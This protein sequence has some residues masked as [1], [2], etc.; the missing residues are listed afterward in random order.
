M[1]IKRDVSLHPITTQHVGASSQRQYNADTKQNISVYF[2]YSN[3]CDRLAYASS[4]DPDQTTPISSLIRFYTVCRSTCIL[5]AHNYL[6]KPKYSTFKI[7]TLI[8]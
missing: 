1:F 2:K 8:M 6:I 5:W 3:Y 4:V 7:I